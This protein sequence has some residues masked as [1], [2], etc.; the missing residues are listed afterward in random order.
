MDEGEQEKF[1]ADPAEE[2]KEEALAFLTVFTGLIAIVVGF[3]LVHCLRVKKVSWIPEAW[4]FFTLGLTLGVW[5]HSG[6]SST[7]WQLIYEELRGS[8]HQLFFVVLLPPIIF[9]SGY[10]MDKK[11]F[12]S[13]FDGIFTYAVLGTLIATFST[14]ILLWFIGWSG[15]TF[16]FSMLDAI[17]FGAII[18]AVDP[19]TVLAVFQSFGVNET[20]Y[21]FVF[22]ESVLN[23]A[24]AIVLYH[25]MLNFHAKH[26]IQ[27][28]DI[29]MGCV[30][31][32]V[33]FVGSLFIG[34]ISGLAS[35]LM[36]KLTRL[37]VRLLLS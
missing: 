26:S 7:R 8:F 17:T 4:V 22:G 33:T 31:F 6:I 16:G 30:Y 24:V 10:N 12:F 23:D 18:S 3:L 29:V 36:C 19:V 14:G 11:S 37:G 5:I 15:I 32:T 35:A 13:N 1:A 21:S 27:A 20:L 28:Q 9:E 25:T 2:A 34:F